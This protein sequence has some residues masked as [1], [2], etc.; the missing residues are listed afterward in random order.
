MKVS[1]VGLLGCVVVLRRG[2]E[3]PVKTKRINST[4]N[5]V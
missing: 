4:S 1:Q 2:S 5:T 3:L